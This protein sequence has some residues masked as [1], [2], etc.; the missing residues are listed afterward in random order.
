[1]TECK[2]HWVDVSTHTDQDVQMFLC[3]RCNATKDQLRS[4]VKTLL[5]RDDGDGFKTIAEIR[6]IQTRIPASYSPA[7]WRATLPKDLATDRIGVA[8]NLE[9]GTI[10]RLALDADSAR[11]LAETIMDSAP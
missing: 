4:P 3:V 7:S 5:Q 10:I 8:F 1:M 6:E 11:N 2:H 9:D